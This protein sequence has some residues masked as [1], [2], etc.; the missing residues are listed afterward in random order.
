VARHERPGMRRGVPMS[1]RRGALGTD[2]QGT[3]G[4]GCVFRVGQT[5]SNRGGQDGLRVQASHLDARALQRGGV[6]VRSEKKKSA[7]GSRLGG[8]P[9]ASTAKN[10]KT[11]SI[12]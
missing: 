7:Y 12:F 8:R 4:A 2:G 3:M 10:R 1:C 5:T 9:C 11:F 6:C